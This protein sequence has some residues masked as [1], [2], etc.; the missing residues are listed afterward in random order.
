MELNDV[1]VIH[2]TAEYYP[3]LTQ[4]LSFGYQSII[5][6]EKHFA[7]LFIHLLGRHRR[8]L[9]KNI[10]IACWVYSSHMS[11][12]HN[13]EVTAA[14]RLLSHVNLIQLRVWLMFKIVCKNNVLLVAIALYASGPELIN[15]PWYC[16]C[17]KTECL[18][19]AFSWWIHFPS[20]CCHSF[21]T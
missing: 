12:T 19:F 2:L 10:I 5:W 1:T 4:G 3:G 16:C 13:S 8:C 9:G 11:A 21:C 6:G 14:W 15:Q 17:A 7:Q 20:R 18:T